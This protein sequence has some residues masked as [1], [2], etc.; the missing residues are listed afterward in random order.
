[1]KNTIWFIKEILK[2]I[3]WYFVIVITLPITIPLACWAIRQDDK[4]DL[5]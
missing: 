2:D 1:M 3:L 5:K 4:D